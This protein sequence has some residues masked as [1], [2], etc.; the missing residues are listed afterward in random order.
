MRIF[1]CSIL[2]LLFL[3]V[4]LHTGGCAAPDLSELNLESLL[5]QSGDLPAG[6]EAGQV[7]DR[8]PA[9]FDNTPQP[10]Q[11]I[12]QRFTREGEDRGGVVVLL[13]SA[14]TDS[15]L[16]YTLVIDSMGDSV[17]EIDVGERASVISEVIEILGVNTGY[18]ELAFQRCGAV[19]HVRFVKNAVF[20]AQA[21]I[22]DDVISAYTRRL[23]ERLEKEL[24]F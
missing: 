22:S 17:Q 7:K 9:M 3:P 14:S 2:F 8:A 10:V 15:D 5:I 1:N 12:D 23:D 16:A 4:A 21:R 6:F 18:A 13:Y 11:A 19:V 24:C 20:E